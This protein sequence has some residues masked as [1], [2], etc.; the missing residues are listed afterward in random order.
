MSLIVRGNTDL[1]DY[2]ATE[3]LIKFTTYTNYL[4]NINE[5]IYDLYKDENKFGAI[6]AEKTARFKLGKNLSPEK[7]EKWLKLSWNTEFLLNISTKNHDIDILRIN[8][9]WMPVLTYYTIYSSLIAFCYS[10]GSEAGNHTTALKVATQIFVERGIPPWSFAYQ[11]PPGRGGH[12][13]FPVKFPDTV[14]WNNLPSNLQKR[15]VKPV[16]MIAVCLR[17]EHLHRR[18][19]I[20]NDVKKDKSRKKRKYQID[21]NYTSIL[22]FLYRLRKRSNY[23]SPD[24]FTADAPHDDIKDFASSL[25]DICFW[26]LM[27]MEAIMIRKLGR[28]NFIDIADKY[29]EKNKAAEDLK[30]RISIFKR[31]FDS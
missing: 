4:K 9:H 22:H 15:G 3:Y 20:W 12:D 26:S 13:H 19:D 28:A 5:F 1:A 11:G 10:N 14:D 29:I 6:L 23:D 24:T 27:Y 2:S 7:L 31:N 30:A 8:N 25:K 17:A 18:D 21:P 16:E